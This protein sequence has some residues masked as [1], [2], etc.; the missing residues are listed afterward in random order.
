MR[1]LKNF[2]LSLMLISTSAFA[3]FDPELLSAAE[4]D[5]YTI[6][7]RTIREVTDDDSIK[8]FVGPYAQANDVPSTIQQGNPID[9]V[10]RVIGVA[11]DLVALGEDLYRLVIKGKPSNTTKYAPISVIP[12]VGNRPVDLLE[13]ENWSMPVKR[14]YEVAW[15]NLYGV[16]VV[17]FR[18]SVFFSYNG[19]Y[20]G[21]GRYLTSVQVLPE[22]VKTLF[23]YDFTAT[24]KLGGIQNNGTRLNPVAAATVLIE[25]TIS[26]VVKAE[27][28]VDTFF[29]TGN[30][31]LKK[32]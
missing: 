14:T 23:G 27:N 19:S 9:Q 7:E 12:K 32:Y 25:Y 6:A 22:Q 17:Y 8:D 24:M 15:K 13:T 10:G 1:L 2:T 4:K 11:R 29:V 31:R 28:N 3:T 20:N 5:Y 21:K 16:E 30:G 18:Y 26:T